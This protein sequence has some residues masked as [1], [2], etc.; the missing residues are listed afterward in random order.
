[1]LESGAPWEKTTDLQA[2]AA[3]SQG[4]QEKKGKKR[5]WPISRI[6]SEYRPVKAVF[7]AVIHLGRR[8]PGGSCDLTRGQRTG[9]PPPY[10]VLLQV[11]FTK[12][13]PLP[14]DLVSS[15]LTVSP[16]PR[17]WPGRF[18]FCCTFPASRRAAVSGHPA[19]RSPD[20]PPAY[21]TRA[22]AR[23]APFHRLHTTESPPLSSP[24]D[25]G[26]DQSSGETRK[27]MR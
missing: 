25:A 2:R 1:M 11:G 26:R 13:P 3:R 22:T 17:P 12:H 23:P 4:G 9:R 21:E 14:T 8:L 18:T 19:L 5:S 20:F 24:A 16:L 10:L 7:G 15:Y 27:R 6:L